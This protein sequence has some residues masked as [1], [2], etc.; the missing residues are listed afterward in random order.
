MHG[1]PACCRRCIATCS[2]LGNAYFR[3]FDSKFALMFF[4]RSTH[5]VVAFLCL[6]HRCLSQHLEE[7][8]AHL[9]SSGY[10]NFQR[11]GKGSGSVIQLDFDLCVRPLLAYEVLPAFYACKT[12]KDDACVLGVCIAE[13]W[14]CSIAIMIIFHFGN[15]A[16]PVWAQL[17]MIFFSLVVQFSSWQR[18]VRFESLESCSHL[19]DNHVSESN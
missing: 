12:A 4:A 8:E 17:L 11:R 3:L 9:V 14:Q 5:Q 13:S 16:V 10:P 7:H 2:I 18:L 1:R 19:S 6:L 15:N